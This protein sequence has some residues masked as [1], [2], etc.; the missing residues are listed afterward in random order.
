ML[1]GVLLSR[2]STDE[3]ARFDDECGEGNAVNAASVEADSMRG[4]PWL[5]RG[6][7]S[8]ENGLRATIDG[9]PWHAAARGRVGA[10]GANLGHV[11]GHLFVEGDTRPHSRVHNQVRF[12]IDCEWQRTKVLRVTL[13]VGPQ[14]FEYGPLILTQRDRLAAQLLSNSSI[15]I[16]DDRRE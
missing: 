6:P 10:H 8:E 9:I 1:S 13:A 7:V 16:A 4:A 11:A 5:L 14:L 12:E 2:G 15:V 3:L